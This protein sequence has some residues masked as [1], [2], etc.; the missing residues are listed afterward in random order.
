MGHF[1]GRGG[2]R[3]WNEWDL[4]LLRILIVAL[5]DLVQGE[6]LGEWI[7]GVSAVPMLFCGLSVVIRVA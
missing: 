7:E 2:G 6:D 5:P 3:E 1:L 4:R